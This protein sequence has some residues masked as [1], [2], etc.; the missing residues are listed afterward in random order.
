MARI[1]QTLD[2]LERFQRLEVAITW[3]LEKEIHSSHPKR[4]TNSC[5]AECHTFAGCCQRQTTL[6][7][8]K[9]A[10]SSPAG[11]A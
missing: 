9:Q 1:Y 5:C 8:D 4:K 2:T 11:D 3:K 7:S 6:P 10:L